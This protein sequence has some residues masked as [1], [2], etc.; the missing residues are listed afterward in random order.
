VQQRI[1]TD[2][3]ARGQGSRRA[4]PRLCCLALNSS[5]A[6]LR[7]VAC[8]A[9]SPGKRSVFRETR[10]L[11]AELRR[12]DNVSGRFVRHGACASGATPDRMCSSV[13][14]VANSCSEEPDAGNSHVRVRGSSPGVTPGSDPEADELATSNTAF[15][16]VGAQTCARTTGFRNVILDEVRRRLAHST[17]QAGRTEPAA[18]AAERHEVLLD[19]R[20]ALHASETAAEQSAVEVAVNSLRTNCGSAAPSKPAATA[21]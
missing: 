9:A 4:P 6:N 13:R 8:V 18:L 1:T 3:A 19:A 12:C 11:R 17:P 16:L 2:R 15:V 20:V 21:A 7:A 10:T 5:P 14:L